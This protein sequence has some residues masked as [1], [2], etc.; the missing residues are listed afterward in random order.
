MKKVLFAVV[1]FTF[2][3]AVP[4]TEAQAQVTFGPQVVLWDFDEFGLGARGDFEL[5]GALEIEEGAFSALRASTNASYLFGDSQQF[6]GTDASWSGI[7][8][9]ANAI[10]PFEI[11]GAVTPFAGAGINHTRFSSSVSGNGFQFGSFSGSSSGLN[12]L[13]GIEFDLGAV[14]AFTELQYSTS[15]AGNLNLSLGVMF[16]G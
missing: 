5:G 12:V 4:P 16:G 13:G 2:F 6:N 14:P 11:D 15:G 8:I 1:A 10:V 9:N 7:L 3:L